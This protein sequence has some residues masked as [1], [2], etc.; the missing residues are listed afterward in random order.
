MKAQSDDLLY[1]PGY[2]NLPKLNIY[3]VSKGAGLL[4]RSKFTVSLN[5][6]FSSLSTKC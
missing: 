1:N 4:L 2:F 6:T 3:L 5:F